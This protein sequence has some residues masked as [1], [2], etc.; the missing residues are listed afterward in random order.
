MLAEDLETCHDFCWILGYL[1]SGDDT[2]MT[3]VCE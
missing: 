3:G 1:S 2:M